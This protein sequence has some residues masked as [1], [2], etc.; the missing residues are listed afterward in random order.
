MMVG[1]ANQSG[2]PNSLTAA[3][4]LGVCIGLSNVGNERNTLN[5]SSSSFC[6]WCI[7]LIPLSSSFTS[8]TESN[9]EVTL[10]FVFILPL[11]L[12]LVLL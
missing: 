5:S 4:S 7:E 11:F 2:I 9:S 8:V 3:A 6:F 1:F 12:F 10:L